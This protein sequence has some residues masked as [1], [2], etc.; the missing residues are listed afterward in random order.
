[1]YPVTVLRS[2]SETRLSPAPVPHTPYTPPH[3]ACGDVSVRLPGTDH[4]M[5]WKS[6]PNVSRWAGDQ[7]PTAWN[8][9]VNPQASGCHSPQLQT[10][11]RLKQRQ[12]NWRALTSP[13][14][15]PAPALLSPSPAFASFKPGGRNIA[16][17]D[18]TPSAG[19]A[20]GSLLLRCGASTA[21]P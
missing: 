17:T 2:L 11:A 9:A 18:T 13:T 16:G 4:M 8:T 3:T 6:E 7:K 20:D 5:T 19:A 12:L 1:M 10:R 15:A 21:G 14:P